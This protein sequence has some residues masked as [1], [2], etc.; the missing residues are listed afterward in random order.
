MGPAI[1][2][3]EYRELDDEFTDDSISCSR[4]VVELDGIVNGI[5]H[6]VVDGIVDSIVDSIVDGLVLYKVRCSVV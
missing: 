4:T 3:F 5:V 1:Q 6:G 2:A